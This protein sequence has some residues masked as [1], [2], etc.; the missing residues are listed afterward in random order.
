MGANKI[1]LTGSNG[2]LGRSLRFFLSQ[3]DFIVIS[4]GLGSDRFEELGG[5]Y[6]EM[7][8]TSLNSCKLILDQYK[9]DIIIN[10]AALTNVDEC[11]KSQDLCLSVNAS[12]L[13]NYINYVK[14]Y[15]T[16][17]IHIS[18]DFV[19]SGS[20]G[21]YV[22]KDLCNPVNHYGLSKLESE[23]ILLD[24]LSNATI[25][26]T[27]L[28]YGNHD[29]SSNFLN[30]VKSSLDRNIRLKI[31]DDQ[32]RTPTFVTDLVQ[33][34]LKILNMKKYG[35]YHI[36]NGERLSIYQ[37]VCNIAKYYGYN[38]NLINKISSKEL[39]Q[40]AQRPND[41]SLLIDKAVKELNFKPTSLLGSLK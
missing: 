30:W 14:E 8:V 21:R 36:S 18:T 26:R 12:S 6:E 4:T 38:V 29:K 1:L 13:L 11:E 2:L 27:S 19:F 22:E 15:N 24:S 25:I 35:I 28:I 31:V 23:K 37:I 16:H 5:V 20:K 9:P 40:E 3:H 10:T 7:D 17:L 34:V 32:Y 33:A 41:S 39:N